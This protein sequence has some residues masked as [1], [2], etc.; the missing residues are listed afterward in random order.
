MQRV[1]P[2]NSSTKWFEVGKLNTCYILFHIYS[3]QIFNNFDLSFLRMI[4]QNSWM[5]YQILH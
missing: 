5:V 2:Y 3:S 1:N 4:E